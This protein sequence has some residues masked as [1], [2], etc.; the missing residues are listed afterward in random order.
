[1]NELF[2]V[3]L[4]KL[5]AH[6]QNIRKEIV[7]DAEFEALVAGIKS[8]G[9]IHPPI[10]VAHP[11]ART[12]FRIVTGH[13]RVAA[14]Q[15]AGLKKLRVELRAD[16]SE[17]DQRDMQYQ[18]NK[19]RVGNSAMERAQYVASELE[20]GGRSVADLAK[21]MGVTQ[22]QIKTSK[23]LAQAPGKA[24]AAINEGQMTLEDT[25]ILA[26][27]NGDIAAQESL[28][29]AWDTW[30]WNIQV[31]RW[32]NLRKAQKEA[33]KTR[34]ELGE[35]GA[36]VADSRDAIG[37]YRYA[38]NELTT[39]EHVAAGHVAVVN[40]TETGK[41]TWYV[42]IVAEDEPEMS[43]EERE[44]EVAAQKA[45]A[46]LAAEL[47]LAHQVRIEALKGVI[48][49]PPAGL[50][51]DL[52][53]KALVRRVRISGRWELAGVPEKSSEEEIE[54]IL[55]KKSVESLVVLEDVLQNTNESQLMGL[56]GWGPSRW[57]NDYGKGWRD[58]LHDVYGYQ[59]SDVERG[60][61]EQ[62]AE[63]LKDYC[64]GC[65]D[66]LTPEQLEGGRCSD[67]VPDVCSECDGG[68]GDGEGYDGKC[69]NCAD[70]TEAD[71]EVA[72]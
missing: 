58:R 28:L 42:P 33:P 68:L 52:M 11:T 7:R 14:A 45:A 19:H 72:E 1:M 5:E 20:L 27:F 25:L 46:D 35:A 2:E 67:C 40:E 50:A 4:A 21:G 24:H 3:S 12:K 34:R 60:F 22:D 44:A 69:G 61:M 10:V 30:N 29:D 41:A 13:R 36:Q 48:E 23:K 31:R 57:G 9:V 16:L 18:E 63:S 53:V 37:D 51:K 26:E 43:P 17:K 70:Q 71:A 6:P 65:G 49:T 39:E 38:D 47:E 66:K 55:S 59:W 64:N 62:L 15:Q 8:V 56:N 54:A 32:R